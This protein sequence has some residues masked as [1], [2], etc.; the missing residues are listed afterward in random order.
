MT[1]TPTPEFS[2]LLP[3]AQ[4]SMTETLREISAT[5]EECAAIAARL[6]LPQLAA[7]SASFK[8]QRARRGGGY[9]AEG[10]LRARATRNCVVTLDDFTERTDIAFKVRF[11]NEESPSEEVESEASFAFEDGPD[12]LVY[13]NE[14]LDLGEAAVQE[15]ALSL[16]PYPRKP[17]AKLAEPEVET[18]NPFAVLKDFRRRT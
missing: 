4:I 1:S 7:F 8:I 10:R 17:G 16:A 2:R 18:P 11:V 6:A 9:E 3:L 5:P 13:E 12:E 15:Y 14:V